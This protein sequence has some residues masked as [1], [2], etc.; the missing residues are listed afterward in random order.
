MG[1]KFN[2]KR[3][4]GLNLVHTSFRFVANAQRARP[5]P[6]SPADS[7]GVC[8]ACSEVSRAALRRLEF[9]QHYLELDHAPLDL[10]VVALTTLCRP[11]VASL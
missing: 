6:P 11:M 3:K 1:A 4:S 7:V 8:D 9:R 5:L 2:A 10:E